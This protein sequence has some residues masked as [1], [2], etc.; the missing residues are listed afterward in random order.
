MNLFIYVLLLSIW[1]NNCLDRN[2]SNGS[3]TAVTTH[4]ES[5]QSKLEELRR[6]ILITVIGVLIIGYTVTCSCFLHY[7]CDGEE[8]HNAAKVKKDD[9]T[10]KASTSSK[11][12]FT[13]SKSPTAGLG[14]P[15]KQSMV[16]SIDKSFGPSSPQKASVPSSAKKSVRRSSQQNPSK[17]SNPKKVLGSPPQ[18]KLH[19]TR[20]PKKAHR[21]AHAH[22]LVGQVSPSYPKKATKPTWP[23]SLQCQVKPTKTPLLYS[24]NQSFP[25]QSSVEKLTKR[26]RYLKPKCPTSAGRAEILSRPQ[27]VKFCRCY[28][29]KCLVCRAVSE[30]FITHISEANIKH[31]PVPLFSRELKHFYK[32]YKK[33]P[34]YITLY[35]NMGDSD[36]TTYNSDGDSD[37]EVTILCDIKCKEDIYRNSRYN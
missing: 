5:K 17:P 32:S 16:S 34:R 26:Q 2:E 15:E 23:S 30:P 19:R 37:R 27:P 13:G 25:E 11:I 4:V 21:R 18:E 28:K 22:K 14:D 7:T 24:K 9:I 31:V 1:T 6:R 20:S 33:K 3:A 10:I 8:A 29:E 12:S 35:G 36:V